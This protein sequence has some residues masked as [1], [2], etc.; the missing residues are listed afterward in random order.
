[1]RGHR[2]EMVK[3]RQRAALNTKQRETER[4]GPQGEIYGSN[5]TRISCFWNLKPRMTVR[6]IY[7]MKINGLIPAPAGVVKSLP[8]LMQMSHILVRSEDSW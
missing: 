1:M 8:R 3:S 7:Y 4:E 5:K 6:A 2:R